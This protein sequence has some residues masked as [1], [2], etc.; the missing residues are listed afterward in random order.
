[1]YHHYHHH[2]KHLL[3]SLVVCKNI[4]ERDDKNQYKLITRSQK[5]IYK[6]FFDSN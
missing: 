5:N 4:S 3:I 1:M 2:A 6:Y